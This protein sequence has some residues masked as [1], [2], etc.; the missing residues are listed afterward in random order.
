M[1]MKVEI[2][3]IEDSIA[4]LVIRKD[5]R[6]QI[7]HLPVLLLPPGSR[8]GD[9]LTLTLERDTAATAAAKERVAGLVKK[10]KKNR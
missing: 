8:E 2:D 1:V 5:P 4:V 9:I 3:R 10:L 7:I 6:E